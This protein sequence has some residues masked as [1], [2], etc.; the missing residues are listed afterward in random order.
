MDGA[1]DANLGMINEQLGRIRT[2]WPEN[3]NVDHHPAAHPRMTYAQEHQIPTMMMPPTPFQQHSVD[4]GRKRH[5]RARAPSPEDSLFAAE[6]VQH[7]ETSSCKDK[8]QKPVGLNLAPKSNPRFP[9]GPW[10]QSDHC[11]S[12]AVDYA[13][14]KQNIAPNRRGQRRAYR[15]EKRSAKDFVAPR[16]LGPLWTIEKYNAGFGGWAQAVSNVVTPKSRPHPTISSVGTPRNVQ[17]HDKPTIEEPAIKKRSANAEITIKQPV[18]STYQSPVVDESASKT[19]KKEPSETIVGMFLGVATVPV[20]DVVIDTPVGTS[21]DTSTDT[22]ITV[23]L[24]TNE[25]SLHETALTDLPA[26]VI[27]SHKFTTKQAVI[28]MVK[29]ADIQYLTASL[30]HAPS[31]EVPRI[32]KEILESLEQ[33]RSTIASLNN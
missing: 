32:E 27:G 26:E 5:W 14:D 4:A 8:R 22:F 1:M 24:T 7:V 16:L 20:A 6:F 25:P 2:A 13:C 33:I 15:W 9:F 3:Y 19:I 29:L 21:A 10:T 28:L 23:E 30:F 12:P 18:A 17:V 31:V 11:S